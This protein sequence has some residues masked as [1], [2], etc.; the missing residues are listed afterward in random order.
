MPFNINDFLGRGLT[1]GG[2]R[3][4]LF[5]VVMTFPSDLGDSG[6]VGIEA[7]SKLRFTC[8]ASSIPASTIGEVPVPYFGRTIKLAGD[9]TFANWGVTV[10]NDED[11][12]VRD[13]F[14][15]W[16]NSINTIVSNIKTS[17]NP[18]DYKSAVANV[19]HYSKDGGIIKQYQ[20]VNIFP[21]NLD[22]MGL[23]WDATNQVQTFGVTFAYDYWIPLDGGGAAI[24]NT[25]A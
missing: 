21:I 24:M 9:R 10:M 17:T 19:T 25:E 16:H 13:A 20:F 4:S 7:L 8:R 5:D 14:E 12:S 6:S 11:Y 18:N 23:D 2:A 3:P 22:E 1:S 15:V